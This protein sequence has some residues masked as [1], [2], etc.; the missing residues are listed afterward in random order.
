MDTE[1]EII[2]NNGAASHEKLEDDL[3][4]H[5]FTA[6][7]AMV[8]VCMTVIG[9]FQFGKLREINSIGDNLLAIDAAAFLVSCALSYIALKSRTRSTRR[10]VERFAD[11][12]FM[13]GL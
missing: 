11:I 9:I 6:S 8:G 10:K 5:I 3:C 1:S 12:I 4:I 2:H 13:I 7:A